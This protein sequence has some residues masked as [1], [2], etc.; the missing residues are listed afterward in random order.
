MFDIKT[1]N[2]HEITGVN[3]EIEGRA[4]SVPVM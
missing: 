3:D 4:S 2:C 1:T